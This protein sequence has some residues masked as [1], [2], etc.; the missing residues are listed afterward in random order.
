METL[1]RGNLQ[2][3]LVF[4]VDVYLKDN[5]FLGIL[6]FDS[7][8]YDFVIASKSTTK[9]PYAEAFR[10]ILYQTL[11]LSKELELMKTLH[12]QNL[13]F[14]FEV[15]DPVFDPHIIP[16]DKASVTLLD[17][18]YR[19]E[20]FQKV[21]YEEL[22]TL[23][24]QFGLKVKEH[25]HRF[26]NWEEFNTWYQGVSND[27]TLEI[28]GFV[29]EDSNGFMTKIKLPYY[30]FWKWMRGMRDRIHK[31]R[32]LP[33]EVA[34]HELAL[35]FCTWLQDNKDRY[36]LGQTDIIKLRNDYYKNQ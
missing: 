28:E 5:G 18:I 11:P 22:Q 24:K 2:D 29:I 1:K 23:G 17:A 26:Y 6:G 20:Q 32:E 3:I 19:T 35:S 14:V 27:F 36:D 33:Q 8:Q 7:S 25:V 34:Q 13:S 30:A 10:N 9:G 16:Y 21:P 15:I 31:G 12:T 4:P